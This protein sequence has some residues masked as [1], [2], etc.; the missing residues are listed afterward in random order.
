MSEAGYCIFMNGLPGSGKSTYARNF[1]ASRRGWLNL[2]VDVLRG[3]LGTATTD[4]LHAGAEV[5]PL[6]VAVLREHL[7]AGGNV[8]FPQLF[9]APDEAAEFEAVVEASGGRVRRTMLRED[10]GECWRRVE[11]RAHRTPHGSIDRN[12]LDLLAESGGL[13]ELQRIDEQL[14]A[15][16]DLP[17]P[18]RIIHTSTPFSEVAGL[19]R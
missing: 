13:S 7:S 16:S 4:F 18:P 1:V 11:E 8:I 15:W 6:A 2:D 17:D 12:I 19:A 10:V 9:Y 5:K 3:L 14:A